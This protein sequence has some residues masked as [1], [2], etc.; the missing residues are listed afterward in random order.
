M[1][2]SVCSVFISQLTVSFLTQQTLEPLHHAHEVAAD[3]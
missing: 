3:Y 1:T 2:Q